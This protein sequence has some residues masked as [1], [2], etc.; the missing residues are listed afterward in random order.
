M[1]KWLWGNPD[2][3]NKSFLGATEIALLESKLKG[4]A[5]DWE[6]TVASIR[7][8]IGNDNQIAYELREFAK[9][10]GKTTREGTR[11]Y[12]N[13]FGE[14]YTRKL[15]LDSQ[16][17]PYID[18]TNVLDS[19]KTAFGLLHGY[20]PWQMP[21]RDRTALGAMHEAVRY[22]YHQQGKDKRHPTKQ[23]EHVDTIVRTLMQNVVPLLTDAENETHRRQA[24]L[25]ATYKISQPAPTPPPAAAPEK[26]KDKG[27]VAP[28]DAAHQVGDQLK[29]V[30]GIN[31][32]LPGGDDKSADMGNGLLSLSG[33]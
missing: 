1:K 26:T 18:K 30:R 4:V 2:K 17:N 23:I 16:D 29:Q 21:P 14:A 32:N 7:M 12:E 20:K 9:R 10:T 6:Q 25:G 8:T 3:D 33:R 13:R 22:F 31:R 28:E 24:V 15:K 19:N 27:A 11:F 5:S